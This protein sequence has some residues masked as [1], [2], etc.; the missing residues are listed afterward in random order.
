MK[1]PIDPTISEYMSRM[2]KR[3]G[4]KNK[5]KGSEYFSQIGKAGAKTRWNKARLEKRNEKNN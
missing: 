5:E 1:I 4:A 3:G 2:G